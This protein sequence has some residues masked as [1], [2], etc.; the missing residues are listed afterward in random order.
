[1]RSETSIELSQCVNNLT[2]G[3]IGLRKQ[4]RDI[5]GMCQIITIRRRGDLKTK[6]IVKRAK[7][8][9]LK[10]LTEKLFKFLNTRQN[11]RHE[12]GDMKGQNQTTARKE[13]S[14]QG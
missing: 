6:K 5:L 3:E 13:C 8:F 2:I 4:I 14:Y 1:M 9:H 11:Q 10:V 12:D 7:I